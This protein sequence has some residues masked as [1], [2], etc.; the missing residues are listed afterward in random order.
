M[1][2][3]HCIAVIG[4]HRLLATIPIHHVDRKDLEPVVV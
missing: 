3:V 4:E 1:L 2:V